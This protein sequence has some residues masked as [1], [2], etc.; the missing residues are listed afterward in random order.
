MPKVGHLLAD[1]ARRDGPWT[2]GILGE[3]GRQGEVERD[4]D[5]GASVAMR[6]PAEFGTGRPACVRRVDDGQEPRGRALLDQLMDTLEDLV[7]AR[8]A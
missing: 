7:V 3:A 1:D 5:E 2:L 4:G 6:V 8:L